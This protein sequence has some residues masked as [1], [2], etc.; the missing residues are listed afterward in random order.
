VRETSGPLTSLVKKIDQRMQAA[1]GKTKRIAGVFV[2][3]VNNSNG[4]DQQLRGMAEKAALKKV[5]LC[6][7]APADAYAVVNEADVTAVIY[8]LG[9]R[10]EQKVTANFALRKGELDEKKADAIVKA[11]SDVL[12]K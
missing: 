3:F 10:F 6:I 9:R 2:I 4:L 12:P 1:A 11:L 8:T 7:G 5:S